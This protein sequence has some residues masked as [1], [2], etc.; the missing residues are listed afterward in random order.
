MYACTQVNR[1]EKY[2]KTHCIKILKPDAMARAY[3][4]SYLGGI[5]QEDHSP[6]PAHTKS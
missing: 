5:D 1:K 6:R 3:N 4:P 2:G